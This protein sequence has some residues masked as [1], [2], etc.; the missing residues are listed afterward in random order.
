MTN[1]GGGGLSGDLG[2]DLLAIPFDVLAM[3]GLFKENPSYLLKRTRGG[4][5]RLRR[6]SRERTRTILLFIVSTE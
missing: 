5:A 4:G 6:P 2:N 3:I 1:L